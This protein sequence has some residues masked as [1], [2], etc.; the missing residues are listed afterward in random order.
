VLSKKRGQF[1]AAAAHAGLSHRPRRVLLL[2]AGIIVLSLA[3]LIVTLAHMKIG[4]MEANPI[5]V[6]LVKSTQ[7]PWALAAFKVL[8]VSVCVALLYRLRR[9][10]EG[11]IA[12]WLAVGILTG[13]SIMWH[14]YT[15]G[16]DRRE[17]IMLAQNGVVN[18][19]WLM[20]D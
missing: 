12:A 13:M 20:L 18:D 2:L 14:C 7:S 9:H 10:A 17:D 16:M 19:H 3:D 4:M 8:T 6:Y 1:L 5:A 11:E 15:E